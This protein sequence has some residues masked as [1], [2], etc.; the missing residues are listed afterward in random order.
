[1]VR[2]NGLNFVQ[3]GG[4]EFPTGRTLFIVVSSVGWGLPTEIRRSSNWWAVPTLRLRGQMSKTPA[5]YFWTPDAIW[6]Q[7]SKVPVGARR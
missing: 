3:G 2:L 5:Y 1:M 4:T 6:T 7:P